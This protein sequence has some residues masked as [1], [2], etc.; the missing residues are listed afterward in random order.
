MITFMW[1]HSIFDVE[2]EALVNPVNTA[3]VMGK[4][5]ALAFK[6][7]FRDNFN[8]YWSACQQGEV[9][10]GRMFVTQD[11]YPSDTA[12]RW[13]INFP[14]KEH[15]KDKSQ[16]EW[17]EQGLEDLVRVI[18]EEGIRSIAIPALGAGLGGLEWEAVRH[19]MI[20]ALYPL[21]GVDIMIFE[22]QAG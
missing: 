15:W 19:R 18:K 20:V 8:L 12:P 17:I 22:P 7:R 6:R 1:S 21:R 11:E 4:G 2:A 9:E 10:V 5:L 3:G 14:T 16:I 13:I